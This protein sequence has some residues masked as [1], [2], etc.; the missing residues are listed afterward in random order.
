MEN[1]DNLTEESLPG[2]DDVAVS[3]ESSAVSEVAP[4]TTDAS[5]EVEAMTLAELNA[6]L[7][8]N[9]KDKDSAIKSIKDTFK[10]VGAKKANESQDLSAIQ[11]KFSEDL[12]FV[13]HPDL[14][15]H[16]ELAE[17]LASKHGVDVTEAVNLDSFKSYVEKSSG[18]DT[19]QK[20]K[21][22]LQSNP[23]LGAVKDSM[24]EA[25]ALSKQAREALQSG[26]AN[27][28]ANLSET[29]KDKAVEAVLGAYNIQ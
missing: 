16:R 2:A 17:A 3:D 15:P 27:Y 21:S 24:Q 20:A 11:R 8:K 7:G 1:Y 28:A 29:A 4:A 18:Y 12:F 19:T 26:D 23:R 25:R 5:A 6:Q 14:E 10:Y 22:V 9:F 13:K